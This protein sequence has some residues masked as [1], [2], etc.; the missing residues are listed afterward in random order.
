VNKRLAASIGA[1]VLAV[2]IVVGVIAAT[3]SSNGDPPPDDPPPVPP[4][5]PADRGV[6][7]SLPGGLTCPVRPR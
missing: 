5:T 6:T 2:E 4:P 7:L 3:T 1:L